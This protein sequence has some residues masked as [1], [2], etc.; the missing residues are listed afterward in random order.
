MTDLEEI[1][2]KYVFLDWLAVNL[3]FKRPIKTITPL[4][5]PFPPE[6]S[7]SPSLEKG[8]PYILC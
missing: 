6:N 7:T 5:A 8:A 2:D 3:V 4:W 1:G